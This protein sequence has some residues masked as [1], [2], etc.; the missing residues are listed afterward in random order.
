M[1]VMIFIA[2]FN[3]TVLASA[4]GMLAVPEQLIRAGTNPAGF[5]RVVTA[6]WE[7]VPAPPSPSIG[8]TRSV[9]GRRCNPLLGASRVLTR[10]QRGARG[11]PPSMNMTN[12]DSHPVTRML[13]VADVAERLQ[14]SQKTIRRKIKDGAIHIHQVGRQHRISEDD[15]LLYLI[16]QRS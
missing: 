8:P 13:T 4:A 16:K 2:S 11:Q 7:H 10:N 9:I 6:P 1:R 14:V 5:G 15:L 12:P 3:F